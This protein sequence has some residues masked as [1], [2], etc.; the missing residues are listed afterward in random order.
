MPKKMLNNQKMQD[1]QKNNK[2]NNNNHKH[3][4]RARRIKQKI[5][6]NNNN[7]MKNKNHWLNKLKSN[8]IKNMLRKTTRKKQMPKM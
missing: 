8:K 1:K 4:R 6:N 2:F 3:K 7:K 5:N